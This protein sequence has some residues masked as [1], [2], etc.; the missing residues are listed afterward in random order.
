M[1]CLVVC[2]LALG[3]SIADASPILNRPRTSQGENGTAGL[4]VRPMQQTSMVR[5]HLPPA[6]G[7]RDGSGA[8]L[9]AAGNSEQAA[10][11]WRQQ[12]GGNKLPAAGAGSSEPAAAMWSQLTASR[13][14]GAWGHRAVAT[15]KL[16][17]ASRSSNAV[18]NKLDINSSNFDNGSCGD[19]ARS[20]NCALGGNKVTSKVPE[21]SSRGQT[22]CRLEQ[23]TECWTSAT[24]RFPR[25]DATASQNMVR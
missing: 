17:A 13:R 21:F 7:Q 1:A 5:K 10:A 19:G 11:S 18:Q 6:L 24:A 22:I 12:V 4:G 14:A 23:I 8:L 3:H 20:C 25:S 15:S 16:V 9:E 2:L